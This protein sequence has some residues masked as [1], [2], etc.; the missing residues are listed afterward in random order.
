MS[1]IG[2]MAQRFDVLRH[3]KVS[4]NYW[5]SMGCDICNPIPLKDLE[6]FLGEWDDDC[7]EPCPWLCED[8]ARELDLLW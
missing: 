3:L 4:G 1:E 6:E 5:E 2:I 7:Q 8:H